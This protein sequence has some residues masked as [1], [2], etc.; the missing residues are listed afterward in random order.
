[1]CARSI[2]RPP[3]FRRV[4]T[5]R[6]EHASIVVP[7]SRTSNSGTAL[8]FGYERLG[9]RRMRQQRVAIV[10]TGARE[11][12]TADA[13]IAPPSA[14]L[15]PVACVGGELQPGD[16]YWG[17]PQAV[18]SENERD[19]PR[20]DI[21]T[22]GGQEIDGRYER[23]WPPTS[24]AWAVARQRRVVHN[25]GGP[26]DGMTIMMARQRRERSQQPR[27]DNQGNRGHESVPCLVNGCPHFVNL[28]GDRLPETGCSGT[29]VAP[30]RI[31]PTVCFAP[32]SISAGGGVN[33]NRNGS[34]RS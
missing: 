29:S 7:R 4:K 1:M 12:V 32:R 27:N 13:V 26:V 14:E 16:R 31:V 2:A 25:R 11:A 24:V 10:A 33:K 19:D 23:H 6:N 8:I 22:R 34:V 17:K 21:T 5:E 3:Q 30:R 28:H 9:C 20:R 15:Q 18:S